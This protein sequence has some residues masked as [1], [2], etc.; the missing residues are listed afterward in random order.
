LPNLFAPS[1]PPTWAVPPPLLVRTQQSPA[2]LLRVVTWSFNPFTHDFDIDGRGDVPLTDPGAAAVLWAA[3]AVTT[4][5]GEH[6]IYSRGYGTDIRTCMRA[7]SHQ[8]TENALVAEM[9]RAVGRDARITDLSSFQFAWTA[10]TLE[11]AYRVILADGRGKQTYLNIP[12]V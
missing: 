7:G 8:A 12:L 3:K 11:V 10:T 6:L 4:Q 1:A 9:R 5:R 2:R